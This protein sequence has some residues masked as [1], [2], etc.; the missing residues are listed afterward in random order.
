MPN[1]RQFCTISR[2]N[3]SSDVT[4][5]DVGRLN[6]KSVDYHMPTFY[7]G[8]KPASDSTT[9]NSSTK[10]SARNCPI[11]DGSLT[12]AVKRHMVHNPCGSLNPGAACM[13]KKDKVGNPICGKAFP[14]PFTAATDVDE[15]GY[16][17][18]RRRDM[19]EPGMS[20][21]MAGLLRLTT[22]PSFRTILTC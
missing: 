2:R 14:K 12:A 11:R 7:S 13:N 9:P 4:W 16:P 8:L 20:P 21:V 6:I 10:S 22:D 18:Y 5:L 17:S 19:A 3:M 15:D 1:S